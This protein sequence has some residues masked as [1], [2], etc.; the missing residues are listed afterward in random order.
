MLNKPRKQGKILQIKIDSTYTQ[1]V[2]N[3]AVEKVLKK[4]KFVIFTPGPEHIL[5]STKDIN[6]RQVLNSSTLNVIDGVGLYAA[7]KFTD[8]KAPKPFILRFFYLVFQG[9]RIG[10]SIISSREKSTQVIKGRELFMELIKLAN[11][12]G[13]RVFLLG[14]EGQVALKTKEILARNYKKIKIE[15]FEGPML[16]LRAH[17]KSS[18]DEEIQNETIKRI[19]SFK[20]HLLFVAFGAPKQEYWIY[21]NKNMLNFGGAIGVGGT[22]DYISGKASLPPDLM[23]NLGL[24]WLWRLFTQPRRV[25]RIINAVIVFPLKVFLSKLNGRS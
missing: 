19:N 6:Y 2:L 23:S 1:K 11:K 13:W 4:E 25:G 12:K 22:F 17:P 3:L 16:D 15:S 20:P 18:Q 24:E 10:L 9:V 21:E 5:K 7:L 14:G 8:L